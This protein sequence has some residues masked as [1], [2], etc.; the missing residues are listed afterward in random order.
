MEE[1]TPYLYTHLCAAGSAHVAVQ[2]PLAKTIKNVSQ[3]FL[4]EPTGMDKTVGETHSSK[5]IAN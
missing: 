4:G 3:Q 5:G 1:V 2:V